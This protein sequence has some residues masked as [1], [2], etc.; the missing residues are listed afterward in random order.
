MIKIA[1]AYKCDNCLE[2]FEGTPAYKNDRLEICSKCLRAIKAFQ[3]KKTFNEP[4]INPY[5]KYSY[6]SGLRYEDGAPCWGLDIAWSIHEI[7]HGRL[8]K[9]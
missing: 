5:D 6:N 1:K 7:K 9:D 4:D 2:L 8:P 3:T